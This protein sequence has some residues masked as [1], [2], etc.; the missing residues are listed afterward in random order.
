[1]GRYYNKNIKVSKQELTKLIISFKEPALFE[2]GYLLV[3]LI[4]STSIHEWWVS[5]Q[6]PEIDLSEE[7]I[8]KFKYYLSEEDKDAIN[9]IR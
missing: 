2:L 9:T 5:R 6:H 4:N 1:M 8:D 3:I 7:W